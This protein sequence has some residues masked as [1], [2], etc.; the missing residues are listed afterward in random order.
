MEKIILIL[1]GILL[2]YLKIILTS[3][4]SLIVLFFLTKIIGNK[5]LT[6][7]NMFDYINSITIGSIAAEMATADKED[8]VVPLIAMLIYGG[9]V[10]L[11]TTITTKSVKMRRFFNGCS[12]VLMDDNKIYMKN[13]KKAKLDLNELLMQFRTNGYFDVSEIHSAFMEPNGN[14][15]IIPKDNYRYVMPKDMNLP[16]TQTKA[17]VILIV[18]GNLLEENLQKASVNKDWLI[19]QIKAQG[20]TDIKDVAIA[21]ITEK[22]NLTVYLRNDEKPSNDYFD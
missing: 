2:V 17:C 22:K 14:V 8:F 7:M 12:I 9:S 15:S 13:I 1:E 10:F 3:I 21:S 18:D 20:A 5:Q 19:T 6:Q 4:G 16:V 11:I